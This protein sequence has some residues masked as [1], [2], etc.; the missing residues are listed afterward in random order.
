MDAPRHCA[1][2]GCDGPVAAWLSY[3]YAG[4]TAWLDPPSD[5]ID[6]NVWGLC[7]AHA[8]KFVVPL[9][10]ACVDR[11]LDAP[12]AR[13]GPSAA[14]PLLPSVPVDVDQEPLYPAVAI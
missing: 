14:P 12:T 1:R 13:L 11:R 10:W 3:E 4:R 6:G 2:P 9:G 7:L 5:E 8:N